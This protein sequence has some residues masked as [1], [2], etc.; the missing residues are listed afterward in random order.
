MPRNK[1]FCG[2]KGTFLVLESYRSQFTSLGLSSLSTTS[3]HLNH[4]TILP[5]SPFE[6]IKHRVLTNISICTHIAFIAT[7]P[8]FVLLHLFQ[9][10]LHHRVRMRKRYPVCFRSTHFVVHITRSD[11]GGRDEVQIMESTE[12][13]RCVGT[14]PCRRCQSGYTSKTLT[15]KNEYAVG[16]SHFW[17]T[18]FV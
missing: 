15:V 12:R 5:R 3:L 10:N 11:V 9:K 16:A 8:C 14:R 18:D 2:W 7:N 4:T 6:Q 17:S 13:V 1:R